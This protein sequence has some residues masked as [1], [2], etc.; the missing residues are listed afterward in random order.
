LILARLFGVTLFMPKGERRT[1]EGTASGP[2]RP[3]RYHGPKRGK[4]DLPAGKTAE[5][6]RAGR[7]SVA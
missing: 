6:Q 5:G 1:S 3:D 7:W 2:L 4:A